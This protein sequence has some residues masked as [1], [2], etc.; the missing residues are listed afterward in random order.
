LVSNALPEAG[1]TATRT[2]ATIGGVLWLAVLGLLLARLGAAAG[3]GGRP[4]RRL[5][6]DGP[7]QTA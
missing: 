4:S 2:T 7:V 1:A 5:R 3:S 6:W